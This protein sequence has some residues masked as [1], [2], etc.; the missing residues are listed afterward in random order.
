MIKFVAGKEHYTEVLS[1]CVKKDVEQ[2]TIKHG[3]SK[4][5]SNEDK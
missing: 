3:K 4:I 1:L 2:K 5:S